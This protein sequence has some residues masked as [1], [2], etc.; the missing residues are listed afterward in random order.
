MPRYKYEALYANGEEASGIV[1]AVSE[2]AAVAQLRQTCEVVLSLT[3]VRTPTGDPL[4]RFRKFS[5]KSLALICQQFAIILQ[6]GLPL[7]QTV[8]LVAGQCADKTLREL[9]MQVSEDVSNGWSLSYSLTQRG[10]RKLPVTFI[11][12]VRS[13]EESGDMV[14][15]FRRMG[16]YYERM[17]KTRSKATSAM[18]YPAF[19][20]SAAVVVVTII[21]VFAVPTFTRTFESMGVELPL[22]TRILVAVSGFMSKYF[23]LLLALLFGLLA[24]LRIYSHTERGGVQLAGFRLRLPVLGRIALMSATS[25]F[26]HTLS[27]MLSAGMPLLQALEIAGRAVSNQCFARSVLNIIPG[28]ESGHSMGACMMGDPILPPMLVQMVAVGESTGSLE[29]TLQILAEYYDNEVD[30]ATARAISLLEPIII[31]LLAFVVVIILFSVYIPMFQ[32]YGAI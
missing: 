22:A 6:A 21:M 2:Q 18:I 14:T 25:Q 24:A 16:S 4:A 3:E 26:A 27:M 30:T 10:S 17:A 28:V 20:L 8:D 7:V 1:E 11:E 31:V 23:L 5:A 29:A 9:L 19:V 13:G 15:A 12:T 32:I